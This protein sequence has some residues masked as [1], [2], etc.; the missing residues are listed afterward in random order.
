MASDMEQGLKKTLSLSKQATELTS[1]IMKEMMKT[2]LS[3][4]AEKKGKISVRQLNK[5]A[6]EHGGK[7]ESIEVSDKNIGDF[8][9]VAKKYDIDFA[10]KHDSASGEFHVMFESGKTDNFKR[11][12]TEYANEKQQDIEKQPTVTRQQLRENA[13]RIQ[14]Q[15]PKKKEKVREKSKDMEYI[16][17]FFKHF[18]T[19]RVAAITLPSDDRSFVD[20]QTLCQFVLC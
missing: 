12:F 3:G 10:I 7:L 6:T 5:R 19:A 20:T 14:E 1:D 2:F 16:G 17:H 4:N 13:Q 11:A 8:L 15:E 18:N 9:S